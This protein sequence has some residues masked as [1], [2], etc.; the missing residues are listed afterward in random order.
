MLSQSAQAGEFDP[1]S[2]SLKVSALPSRNMIPQEAEGIDPCSFPTLGTPLGL[3]EAVERAMCHNPKTRQ[4]WATAK[5]QAAELG[6]SRSAYLP[7]VSAT[8]GITK[9]KVSSGYGAPFNVTLDSS[10]SVRV[11]SFKMSLVL[12]D[13]GRTSANVDRAQAALD[14]A[15][16]AQDATLQ[17][18]FV[19]AAQAYYDILTAVST[20]EA[21]RQAENAAKESYMA[22]AAKYKAGIGTLADQLQAQTA[23]SKAKLDTVKADADVKNAQGALAAAMGLPAN[24]PIMVMKRDGKLPDISFVKSVDQLMEEAKQN[25]PSLIAAKAQLES[26]MANVRM[27]RA[28]GRPS[29]T[30][31]AEVNRQKQSSQ[32]IN[33]VSPT[34]D[35][36]R[37]KNVSIQLNIPLF[38]GF[39]R[40]YKVM[41]AQGQAEAKAAELADAEQQVLLEVWKNYQS[42]TAETENMRMTD[43]L[44]RGAQQSFSVARGRY[45]AGVGNMLELLNAQTELAN[46][47]QKRIQS[48]SNWHTARLK[49]AQSIG[50]LGL[51]AVQ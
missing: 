21:A 23:Y 49:V 22:A 20:L 8:F 15:N 16:A 35:T 19:A 31:G 2:V 11:G 25:H 6:V 38:E 34:P 3:V 32:P 24:T 17:A 27:T 13:F 14:A 39:G 30:L 46:A 48:V 50:K 18:A 51:W 36:T 43:D 26:A 41:S 4:A 7:Q 44:L 12:T 42:L 29:V 45:K 1:F 37:S 10:Q 5:A 40:Q 33:L 28:E 47:E 9:Q